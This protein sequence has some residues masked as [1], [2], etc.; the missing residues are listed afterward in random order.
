M[1]EK[2]KTKKKIIAIE[3][4]QFVKNMNKIFIKKQQQKSL[5]I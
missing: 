5:F 4:Q 1:C 3:K 2:I